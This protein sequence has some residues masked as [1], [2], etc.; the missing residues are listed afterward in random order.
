MSDLAALALRQSINEPTLVHI[1]LSAVF[2]SLVLEDAAEAVEVLR[3]DEDLAL[4]NVV[5]VLLDAD[6]LTLESIRFMDLR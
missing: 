6:Q 4:V 3:G 2:A 1:C 5:I